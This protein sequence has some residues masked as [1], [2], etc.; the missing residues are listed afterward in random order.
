[1][2]DPLTVSGPCASVTTSMTSLWNCFIYTVFLNDPILIAL[3]FLFFIAIIGFVFRLPMTV[4][5]IFGFGMLLGLF[6]LTR[7]PFLIAI[8]LAGV[9]LIGFFTLMALFRGGKLAGD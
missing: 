9:I 3:G 7:A 4:M 5:V 6:Y 8:I 2:V 1:M